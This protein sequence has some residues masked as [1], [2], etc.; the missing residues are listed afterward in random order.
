MKKK[1]HG[2]RPGHK[3][4][5]TLIELLV[6]IAIIGILASLLI[7]AVAAARRAAKRRIA[8]TDVMAL[9]TAWRQYFSTYSRWPDYADQVTAV[10]IDSAVAATLMGKD[11][12]NNPR[13][14]VFMEFS[15]FDNGGRP[16]APWVTGGLPTY[17]YVKFDTD[18]DN[19]IPAG[20]GS[21]RNPGVPPGDTSRPVIVWTVDPSPKKGD[22]YK[23]LI[24]SWQ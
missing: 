13:N 8:R 23:G 18:F 9:A 17:Y 11:T 5:F 24:G 16:I 19:I 6:V 20:Q 12:V 7:P 2:H 4:A 1:P 10:Q 22:K 14:L 21:A 3:R 15:R